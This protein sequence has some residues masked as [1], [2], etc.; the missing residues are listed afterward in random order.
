MGLQKTIFLLCIC[1]DVVET[2][3]RFKLSILQSLNSSIGTCHSRNGLLVS[4]NSLKKM[5]FIF[6]FN[7]LYYFSQRATA[8]KTF[9]LPY[10]TGSQ[11]EMEAWLSG[12]FLTP[13]IKF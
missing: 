4:E 3:T 12:T 11:A 7:Y 8:L 9:V 10:R 1:C 2:L 13:Q 6:V 5:A